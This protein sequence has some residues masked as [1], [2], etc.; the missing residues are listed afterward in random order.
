MAQQLALPL[1]T[2]PAFGREDFFVAPS[3]ASV[4]AAVE[5]WESWPSGT[6][7]VVG[8]PGSGKTHLAQV[9]A[10]LAGAQVVK[11]P[12]LGDQQID[13]IAT[14]PLAIDGADLVGDDTCLFHIYNLMA[15]NRQPLL[16]TAALA[17]ARWPVTLPDLISR[18]GTVPVAEIAQPDDMLLTAVLAKH[19]AD[20]GIAPPAPLIPYL[21]PRIERS[22]RAAAQIVETLDRLALSEGRA[23]GVR[24]AAR[25]LD[26][27]AGEGA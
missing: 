3:N 9:F 6:L 12:A 8:A 17:P 14:G 23:I 7:A 20:R 1:A 24:L 10:T 16:L 22:L 25:V 4:L 13:Q 11:G 19:F 21:V 18:L 5:D 15:Q 2:R 26:N 27:G